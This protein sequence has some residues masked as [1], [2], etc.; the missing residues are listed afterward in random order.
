MKRVNIHIDGKRVLEADVAD[1]F[2]ARFRGL[3]GKSPIER[4]LW[5]VPCSDIH[6]FFMKEEIDVLFVSKEGRVL[7][8]IE[9]MPKNS[10]SGAVRGA[11]GVL[12]LP[13]HTLRNMKLTEIQTIEI[14]KEGQHGR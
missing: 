12:E 8:M 13:A 6:T 11:Y 14:V 9:T 1:S 4:P 2:F 7:R 10:M 5:I 3:M